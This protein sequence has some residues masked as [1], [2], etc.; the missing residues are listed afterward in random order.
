MPKGNRNR[1]QANK[2][3]KINKT[4]TNSNRIQETSN[5]QIT[6]LEKSNAKK[7]TSD[8]PPRA[9]KKPKPH[10]TEMEF[11]DFSDVGG[12]DS[13]E[14]ENQ[15]TTNDQITILENSNAKEMTSDSPPRAEKEP[16]ELGLYDLT[17]IG[18]DDSIDMAELMKQLD[19][20]G[21]AELKFDF[22][23]DDGGPRHIF[24]AAFRNR[25]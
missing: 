4:T 1:G 5:D 22:T 25:R 11:L 14:Q 18:S 23:K 9:E 15:E 13:L 12:D 7:M 20:D 16:T 10:W 24:R 2:N 19:T 21:V 8:S 17:N 3:E 6:M